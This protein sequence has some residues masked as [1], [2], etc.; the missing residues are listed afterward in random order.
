MKRVHLFGLFITASIG[1][2]AHA[3]DYYQND[4]ATRG[5]TPSRSISFQNQFQD[6]SNVNPP[7]PEIADDDAARRLSES[8]QRQ[9]DDGD[10]N[11]EE[12]RSRQSAPRQSAPRQ[13]GEVYGESSPRMSSGSMEGYP[14]AGHSSPMDAGPGMSQP[15]TIYYSE[16]MPGYDGGCA[17]CG[18]SMGD[19]GC[20]GGRG[21]SHFR[22]NQGGG[23]RHRGAGGGMGRG[24]GRGCATG[25]CDSGFGYQDSYGSNDPFIDDA[26]GYGPSRRGRRGGDQFYDGYN[27]YDDGCDVVGGARNRGIGNSNGGMLGLF[28]GNRNDVYTVVGGGWLLLRRD[29]ADF[30]PLSYETAMPNNRLFV[31]DANL[32]SQSGFETFVARQSTQGTGVEMRY[33]GLFEDSNSATLGAMPTTEIDGLGDITVGTYGSAWPIYN[34]ADTHTISRDSELH[35]IEANFVRFASGCGTSNFIFRSIAGLRVIRFNDGLGYSGFSASNFGF[36]F[37]TINYDIDV[38]N[39]IVAG[40]VGG[41]GEYCLSDRL[42]LGFGSIVGIGGNSIDVDQNIST[43]TGVYGRNVLGNDFNYMNNDTDTS[44]FGELDT[45][46]FYHINDNCRLSV[47][48]RVFGIT[49]VALAQDQ[50]GRDF[51]D[52][53]E[54]NAIKRDGSVMYQGLTIGAEFSR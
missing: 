53:Q 31:S 36:D 28:S 7:M 24:V 54:L 39:T 40:Q 29:G 52:V 11:L 48:Y 6:E 20:G 33:W 43:N 9:V 47:G 27:G 46:L 37:N 44:M 1:S 3:Q 17:G 21:M 15:G 25:D 32:E 30:Q 49:G 12:V 2:Y 8:L 19:C 51:T 41:R 34:D 18:S 16:P 10:M 35:N 45:R 38:A 26:Y 13:S 42:R 22:G 5:Q 50:I 14:D 4:R 23:G